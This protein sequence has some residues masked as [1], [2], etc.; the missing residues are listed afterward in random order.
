MINRRVAGRF[1]RSMILMALALVAVPA[2]AIAQS[3]P[4][5]VVRARNE[6]VSA[7]LANV[8]DE[9]PESVREE[10]KDVI[11]GLLDFRELSRLALARH[12]ADRTPE[13][14]EEF[15]DLFREL[16]RNSSVQKLEV[17]KADSTVY[18]PASIEGDKATL[19]TRAFK[20]SS[21]IEIEYLM[22]RV[23]G[24]WLAYD[25]VVDGS[26]TMRTYRDSFIREL[27]S[28]SFEAMMRRMRDRLNRSGESDS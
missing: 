28:T 13:E 20:G 10:L 2:G 23:D 3:T 12:W 4:E 22:H 8:G 25:V 14:Q 5:A 16:V 1:R 18:E 26:S 21:E 6:T 7:T 24:E 11:N 27:Q 15:I 19:V 9:V 17:Y